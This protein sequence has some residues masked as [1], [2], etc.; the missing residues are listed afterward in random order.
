MTARP[1]EG[2]CVLACQFDDCVAT[3]VSKVVFCKFLEAVILAAGCKQKWEASGPTR[4]HRHVSDPGVGIKG[5]DLSR[6]HW[7]TLHRLR[8]GFATDHPWRSG[9]WRTVQHVS[10]ASQNRQLLTS[11][12]AAHYIDHHP[13]LASSKLGL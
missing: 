7:T 5:E 4:V 12:T 2:L 9:G 10:V 8:T 1:E 13:K 11:S 6:K 3:L